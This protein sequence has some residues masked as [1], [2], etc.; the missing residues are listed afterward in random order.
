MTSIRHS[1]ET[2]ITPEAVASFRSQLTIGEDVVDP[3][4]WAGSVRVA[5]G[6]APESGWV[7]AGGST[8]CGCCRSDSWS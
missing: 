6:I 2:R 4:T 5:H 1:P 7:T 8:C 3:S